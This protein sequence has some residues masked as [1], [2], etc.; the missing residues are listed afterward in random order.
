MQF[1]KHCSKDALR[2]AK[3]NS[4]RFF[5]VNSLTPQLVGTME[6]GREGVSE[7]SVLGRICNKEG[8]IMFKSLW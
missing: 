3:G 1:G 6:M 8:S 2:F 5:Q 7:V 4:T